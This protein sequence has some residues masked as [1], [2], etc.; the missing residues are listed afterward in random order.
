M[1]LF[2]SKRIIIWNKENDKKV[3]EN[4]LIMRKWLKISNEDIIE[5]CKESLVRWKIE[6]DDFEFTF[7]SKL[8]EDQ[9]LLF[10]DNSNDTKISRL[11]NEWVNS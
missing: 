1:D 6:E 3:F 5:E 9:H 4:Q 10:W 7:L 8:S 2:L 11:S